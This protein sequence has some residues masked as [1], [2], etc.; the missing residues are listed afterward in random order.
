MTV[1]TQHGFFGKRNHCGLRKN[2]GTGN[3]PFRLFSPT[4]FSVET[5]RRSTKD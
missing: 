3:K 5:S 2:S 1:A 4:P